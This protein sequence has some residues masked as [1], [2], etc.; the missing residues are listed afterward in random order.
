MLVL[1][2]R[3][4]AIAYFAI[5][6][7]LGS[8]ISFAVLPSGMHVW[9]FSDSS[10]VTSVAVTGPIAAGMACWSAISLQRTNI[11]LLGS[12]SAPWRSAASNQLAVVALAS[13][14]G[15]FSAG[16]VVWGWTALGATWGAVNSAWVT[17]GVSG[18]LAQV[19]LGYLTGMLVPRR[20]MAPIAAVACYVVNAMLI[21][22]LSPVAQLG[23]VAFT[24]VQRLNPFFGVNSELALTQSLWLLAIAAVASLLVY[25]K[26]LPSL[27]LK[28]GLTAVVLVGVGTLTALVSSPQQ[29]LDYS[30]Q[31]DASNCAGSAP[32]VCLH[33]AYESVRASIE[34]D[35]NRM[36]ERV[37]DTPFAFQKVEQTDRGVADVTPEGVPALHVDDGAEGWSRAAELELVQQMMD[38]RFET[39]WCKTGET[40]NAEYLPTVAFEYWLVYGGAVRDLGLPSDIVRDV[41]DIDTM[42]REVRKAWLSENA[43][44]LCDGS[45]VR[46]S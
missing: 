16:G 44:S 25:A 8:V 36:A 14:A 43:N 2:R 12:L 31:I 4:N 9:A 17:I 29:P 3:E 5:L 23:S 6:A 42:P 41:R 18:T 24:N 10:L 7:A 30:V 27:A 34:P 19:S 46:F 26:S 20:V 38:P 1:L 32:E 35:L 39:T 45:G 33:P 13:V 11:G 40:R 15:Y 37:A 21:S 28:V 22:V